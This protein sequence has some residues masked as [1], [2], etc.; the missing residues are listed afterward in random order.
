MPKLDFSQCEPGG[1]AFAKK[2]T[3][4]LLQTPWNTAKNPD[5]FLTT[6]SSL[7]AKPRARLASVGVSR[8]NHPANVHNRSTAL[9]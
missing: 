6:T 7:H 8:A 4:A 5:Q 3:N 9:W 1:G 2:K